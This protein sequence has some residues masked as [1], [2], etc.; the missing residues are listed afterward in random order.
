[1][2]EHGHEATD[3]PAFERYEERFDPG[4]GLGGVE[5][6]VPIAK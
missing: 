6:W 2:S 1:L 4:T 3:G 5:I